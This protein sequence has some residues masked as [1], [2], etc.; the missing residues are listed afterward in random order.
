MPTYEYAC[1]K[2]RHKFERFQS[3]NAALVKTCPKCR[4]KVKRLLGGGAGIIFKGSGK[5]ISR[6]ETKTGS[7]SAT[8]S[9]DSKDKT[10]AT[11]KE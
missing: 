4:G 10:T 11:K 6:G 7:K 3:M 5:G 2:C 1:T 8:P 9:S